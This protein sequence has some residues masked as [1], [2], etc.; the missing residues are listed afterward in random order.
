MEG[1]REEDMADGDTENLKS[2]GSRQEDAQV[3]NRFTW[4]NANLSW[5]M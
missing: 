5:C 1:T 4:K 3:Q 2:F